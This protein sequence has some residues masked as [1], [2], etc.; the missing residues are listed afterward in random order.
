MRL[1]HPSLCNV[2]V[3]CSNPKRLIVMSSRYDL[4]PVVLKFTFSIHRFAGTRW[5]KSAKASLSGIE[6][7][8]GALQQF[9]LHVNCEL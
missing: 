7:L 5:S 9:L 2:S 1:L 3:S 8:C 4:I 6:D